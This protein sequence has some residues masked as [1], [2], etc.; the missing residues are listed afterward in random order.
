MRI[1]DL[2]YI[3]PGF[4]CD[5]VD[6]D[7]PELPM[8]FQD[9]MIGFYIEPGEKCARSGYVF[10]AGVFLVSCIDALAR[11]KFGDGVGGR[12]RK[13]LHRELHFDD[14]ITQRFYDDFRNGLVHEARL[15]NGGQF[16]LETKTT[17]SELNGL[18]RIN[19]DYLAQEVR[20]ALHS[21][22]TFF[23]QDDRV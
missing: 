22:V 18:L 17:V 4:R 16:S 10:A 13:F 6:L 2:L 20:A 1:G 11:F 7:G 14:S 23:S 3:G 5:Q 21:Y 15:K 8:Q 19:P 9:R 12:F